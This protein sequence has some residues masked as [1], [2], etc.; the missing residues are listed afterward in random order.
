MNPQKAIRPY[1]TWP[2]WIQPDQFGQALRFKDVQWG[3]DGRTL[4]WL[5][6]RP[7]RPALVRQPPLEGLADLTSDLIP[8][9]GLLYGGGE[10][11]VRGEQ[12]VFATREGRLYLRPLIGGETRP[13]TPAFGQCA[14]PV[15][16]PD[17]AWAIYVHS[18]QGRDCL[19]ITS[20]Q[21]GTWPLQLASGA[22]FY[23]QPVWHPS[24]KQVAWVE[25]SHPSMPWDS[26]RLI[27]ADLDGTPP[28]IIRRQRIAGDAHTPVFQPEFS[29]D[30]RWLSY[31]L[32]EE[33]WD[34]LVILNLETGDH[35]KVTSGCSLAEPAWV[36]GIRVYGWSPDCG[37]IAYIR[38][39]SGFSSLWKADLKSGQMEKVGI[40]PYTW[41][42]QLSVS[43]T[44]GAIACIASASAIPP[45]IVVLEGD[46]L[47]TI[48]RSTGED[49]PPEAYPTPR[50]VEWDS[51]EGE[52]IHGLYFSPAHPEVEGEGLPPAILHLHS[53]PTSQATSAFS[54]DAA[55]F[56][57]R[58]YAYLSVNYRGS[59]G[60]GRTYR[61]ALYGAWGE[62]DVEDAASA[63]GFLK[64]QSLADGEKLILKGGSAGGFSALNALIRYPSLFRAAICAYP[65]TDLFSQLDTGFK[66]EL[67]YQDALIGPLPEA[68][69]LY[70]ER[71]P[72]FH[73]DQI[74]SPLALFHGAEDPVVPV[75][76]SEQLAAALQRRGVPL[77]YRVFPGEGHGWRHHST[78]VEMYHLLEP[79]L[80]KEV[81]YR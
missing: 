5:E 31:I 14:S 12:V 70:Q 27:L 73:A 37:S 54:Q 78:E 26:S 44:T 40:E 76:E 63:A 61:Q 29:P 55:F 18:D 75:T 9:G 62:R 2:G 81:I 48:R 45:R 58:G 77:L 32:T 13:L 19:A 66:F 7:D 49:L 72:L 17:G 46:K 80:R 6:S 30:G 3:G 74:L 39:D 53:G 50:A 38:N 51:P 22:D 60:Y 10:F 4:I 16:S 43:P 57:S 28:R 34:S 56:T 21:E 23:M 33:E 79:F 52:S 35:W 42:S 69:R 24:G 64:D 8:S 36:E 25:W 15:I 11:T 59:S 47:C 71:S 20:L 65:V 67:H 68:A 41:L 1:G